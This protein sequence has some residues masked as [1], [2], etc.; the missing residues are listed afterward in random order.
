MHATSM[1]FLLRVSGLLFPRFL[2]DGQYSL[3]IFLFLSGFFCTSYTF[4]SWKSRVSVIIARFLRLAVFNCLFVGLCLLMPIAS[5]EYAI[6]NVFLLHNLVPFQKVF[7]TWTWSLSADFQMHCLVA[8]VLPT[9]RHKLFYPILTFI[10][11]ASIFYH[12]Y[13]L[14]DAVNGLG[15]RFPMQLFDL[16]F[17]L[18]YLPSVAIFHDRI[19]M[20]ALCRVPPFLFGILLHFFRDR[21]LLKALNRWTCVPVAL[22]G[23]FSGYLAFAVPFAD[24]AVFPAFEKSDPFATLLFGSSFRVFWSICIFCVCLILEMILSVLP[25]PS[26]L[27]RFVVRS[28]NASFVVFLMHPL[29]IG[30]FMEATNALMDVRVMQNNPRFWLVFY[31]IFSMLWVGV[32]T[33]CIKINE[34]IAEPLERWTRRKTKLWLIE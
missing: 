14:S 33:M 4:S 13:L 20:N 26:V 18:P 34:R 5:K 3:D 25:R 24:S 27:D 10:L 32:C 31:I 15:L 1:L 6:Y 2:L 29:C 22:I 30:A 23:V 21:R 7:A 12:G 19:Y 8:L 9:L 11:L 17:R 16:D 28:S